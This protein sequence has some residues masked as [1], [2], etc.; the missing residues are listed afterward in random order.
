ML[1]HER[2]RLILDIISTIALVVAASTLTFMTITRQPPIAAAAP[3]A[4]GGPVESVDVTGD[5]TVVG[6]G[7][8]KGAETAKVAILEFS[9]FQCPYC[10]DFASK[11]L[12]QL[13]REFIT[14]GTTQLIFRHNPLEMIHP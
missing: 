4:G 1:N 14:P 3:S 8:V 2:T 10:A 11:T 7:R 9:D 6:K 5:T 12:P 13:D